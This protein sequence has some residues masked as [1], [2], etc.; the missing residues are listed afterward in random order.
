M[1]DALTA[2]VIYLIVR[3]F[4]TEKVAFIA[5][6][7]YAFSPLA[8]VNE[9]YIWMNPQPMTLCLLVRFFLKRE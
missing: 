8:I 2:P 4:S 1:A 5:G 9:G 3:K 7:G 6:L